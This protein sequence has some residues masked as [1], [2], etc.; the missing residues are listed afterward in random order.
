ML[1]KW[2]GFGNKQMPEYW[3]RYLANFQ[4]TPDKNRFVV[5]DCKGIKNTDGSFQLLSI[6]A[7]GIHDAQ[8]LVADSVELHITHPDPD[9]QYTVL[10]G[11]TPGTKVER[12]SLD[13][14]ISQFLDFIG[15][16]QLVGFHAN[17]QVNQLNKTLKTLQ[18]GHLKN[19]R[20]DIE[21]IYSK[22]SNTSPEKRIGLK[23][24]CRYLNIP[25]SDRHSAIVDAYLI[26][27]MFLKMQTTIKQI[28]S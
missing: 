22:H 24:M 20:M 5:F 9:F 17:Y 14:A 10:A 2:F 11:Y 4:R 12:L 18:L 27:L 26:G 23:D 16:S 19:Q 13:E 21:A 28:R 25:H 6:G 1:L 7:I 8:M 3:K 15:S